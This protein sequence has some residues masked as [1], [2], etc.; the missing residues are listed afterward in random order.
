MRA[1]IDINESTESKINDASTNLI[2]IH[3]QSPWALTQN[4]TLTFIQSWYIK[5][6]ILFHAF[7][8]CWYNTTNVGGL[9]TRVSHRTI[10]CRISSIGYGSWDCADQWSFEQRML[11]Y[12]GY[13][14]G[15]HYAAGTKHSLP[16]ISSW[17]IY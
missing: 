8:T 10:I 16:D 1:Y 13:H 17:T 6:N 15:G 3:C 7:F 2:L 11:V 14:L 12:Y 4:A 9:T 5:Y